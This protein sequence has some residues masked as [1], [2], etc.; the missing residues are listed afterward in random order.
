M[1]SCFAVY[2][3]HGLVLLFD[4]EK[5]RDEF[6]EHEEIVHPDCIPVEFEQIASLIRG[7][8]PTWD[9]SFGCFVFV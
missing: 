5:Q 8:T 7:K 6:V 4:S 2:E 9:I 1:K 3:E